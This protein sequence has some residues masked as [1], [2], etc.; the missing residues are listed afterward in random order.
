MSVATSLL[1]HIC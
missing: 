1:Y